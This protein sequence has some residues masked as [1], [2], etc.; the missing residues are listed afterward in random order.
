M[1][2]DIETVVTWIST[3]LQDNW[4]T[5]IS[6]LSGTFLG[7]YLAFLFERRHAE[8]K[9]RDA[10]LAA[11]KAAQFAIA[12]QLRGA[13]NIKKQVLDP[14][15]KDPERHLTLTPFTIHAKFPS[16]DV[17]SLT[18]MLKGEGAQLLNELMLAAHQFE[19]LVGALQER[20]LRHEVMQ[21]RV[22]E[23]GPD[24]GLDRATIIILKDMTDS[25]YGLGDDVVKELQSAFERLR[26][27][28]EKAFPGA[29]AL[30]V[31]LKE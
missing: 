25:I 3:F 26:T 6:A 19:T 24:I 5:S 14:K 30:S 17:A 13:M 22:S 9:E 4:Q 28:I 7:A 10:N 18:F 21:R 8:A 20:S 2:T 12:V 1:P 31:E 27:Y 23:Q 29:K 16:L 15:H 11:A